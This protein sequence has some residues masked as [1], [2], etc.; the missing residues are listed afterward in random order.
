MGSLGSTERKAAEREKK[1]FEVKSLH[2]H[3]YSAI[4]MIPPRSDRSNVSEVF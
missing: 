1:H 2:Y 3:K 4:D